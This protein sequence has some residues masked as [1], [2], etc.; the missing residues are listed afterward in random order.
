MPKASKTGSF[1]KEAAKARQL[2]VK[3][4][5][6]S[7]TT[8]TNQDPS[9]EQSETVDQTASDTTTTTAA[10]AELSRGQRKR[11]AKRQQYLKRQ[12]LILSSLKLQH[13]QDQQKRIDGLDAMKDAL[14]S[15]VQH[16]N[17]HNSD[18][19]EDDTNANT[20][21]PNLL[22]TNKSRQSLVHTESQQLNLVLQHPS[23]QQDPFQAIRQHLHNTLADD[24]TKHARQAL[25]HRKLRQQQQAQKNIHK[26]EQTSRHKNKRRVRATRSKAK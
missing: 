12:Q 23:F 22:K 24:K 16:N 13:Q 11:Q 14:L 26:K 9:S 21:K 18:Q 17:K 19:E 25:Q 6:Q 8:T 2:P 5:T 1:R 7:T 4:V 10:A 15:T 20:H 3:T